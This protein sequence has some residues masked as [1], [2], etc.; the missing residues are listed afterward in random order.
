MGTLL[1]GGTII[2]AAE[3]F[4]A[5]VLVEGEIITTIGKSIPSKG[6]EVINCKGKYIMPGGIDVHTHLDLNFGGTFSNDDF[7]TGHIAAAFGGTTSHIDFVIQSKG[8]SLAD[9]LMIWREKAK[10]AC[11]DYGFHLAVT[12]LREEVMEKIG[13]KK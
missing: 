10:K 12:D 9:A 3:T 6:H 7:E 8:K 1:K 4:Q 2:T 5:D 11:V 13:F